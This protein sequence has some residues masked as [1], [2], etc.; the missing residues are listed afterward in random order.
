MKHVSILIPQG[1]TSVVNIEGSHQ[2]MNEVNTLLAREG[3]PPLFKVQLVGA[4]HQISQRGLFTIT[5]D[6]LIDNVKKE[7]ILYYHC[8]LE[9]NGKKSQYTISAVSKDG[10]QFKSDDVVLG[11]AYF[12]VFKWKDYYYAIGRSSALYRSKDPRAVFEK[13]PNPFLKVQNPSLLRHSA[14]RTS[15]RNR[16]RPS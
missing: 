14:C 8:P 12:R 2:I 15:Q 10:I 6:V 13:G 1:H 11:E 16:V 7:F 4:S 3:K 9:H 5:P